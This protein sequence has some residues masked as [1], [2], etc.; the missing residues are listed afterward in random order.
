MVTARQ[1]TMT[2]ENVTSKKGMGKSEKGGGG[3]GINRF[4]IMIYD[5][6]RYMWISPDVNREGEGNCDDQGYRYSLLSWYG[7][8]V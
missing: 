5:L 6:L 8:A 1:A 4:F 7:F 3:A 2:A